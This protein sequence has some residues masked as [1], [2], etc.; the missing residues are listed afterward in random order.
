[1]IKDFSNFCY[2][3]SK[4]SIQTFQYRVLLINPSKLIIIDVFII[5]IG[6]ISIL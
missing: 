5:F 3:K 4:L 2:S 6:L 1:M